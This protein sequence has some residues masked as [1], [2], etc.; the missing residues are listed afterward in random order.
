[1]AIAKFVLKTLPGIDRP[2]IA[3]FFPTSRGESVMLDLG[4]NLECDADNL[5]EFAVMGNV[6]ART[7]LGMLKPT[8]GLLN[9]G[10]EELKGHEAVREAAA[11]L[12]RRRCPASFHG[13]VEG[14][15]IAARHGRRGRDRRLHRQRRAEDDRRHGQ[16]LCR[17]PAR[18]ASAA[19]F[20]KHRLS[21]GPPGAE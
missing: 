13:F 17:V 20:G 3:S 5:V 2:A 18:A 21:A 12:R 15:D 9:V 19:R 1:M 16:A 10:S 6:F 14:D 7:V 11:M 4:A 8:V